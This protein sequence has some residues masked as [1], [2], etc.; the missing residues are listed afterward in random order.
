MASGKGLGK[1]LS[2]LFGEE[3]GGEIGVKGLSIH[4]VE[5]NPNQPRRDFE[6]QA[7]NELTESIR[8]NGVLTPITVRKTGE[9]YQIIAGE[10]R[11]RAA[12]AA[13]LTEIPA[14]VLDVG[15]EAVYQLALVENLQRSDLN[16]MEEAQ[17]YKKLMEESRLTQEQAAEII[18]KS[19]PY[20]ANTLRLLALP[21]GVTALVAKGD[22]SAGH[23]RTLIGLEAGLALQV[24]EKVIEEGLSVRDT[25]KLVKRIAQKP[26]DKPAK[27]E[28]RLAI[29]VQELERSLSGDTGHKITIKHGKKRGTVSIEYYGND[30]LEGI[31]Q[32]VREIKKHNQR[33]ED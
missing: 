32:A 26:Q 10:R 1:G 24:A 9:T 30:D 3:S 17:G 11:W 12:R 29:Y 31:C 13:G 7:L 4:D 14:H 8:K 20:V 33:K 18:G 23:A 16:P 19:R 15:E 5:P 21:A 2:A 22:L 6:P 25:E 28:D 27:A